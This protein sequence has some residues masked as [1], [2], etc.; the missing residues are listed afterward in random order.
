MSKQPLKIGAWWAHESMAIKVS[1]IGISAGP[2]FNSM[3][4][5]NKNERVNMLQVQKRWMRVSISF[6]QKV[7]C[8]L[9]FRFILVKKLLVANLLCSSLNWKTISFEIFSCAHK[10]WSVNCVPV[11]VFLGFDSI[12]FFEL[13]PVFSAFCQREFYMLLLFVCLAFKKVSVTVL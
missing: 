8:S 13:R 10:R 1:R 4:P 3:S 2:G 5:D 9:S 7:H 12:H 6:W 11:N